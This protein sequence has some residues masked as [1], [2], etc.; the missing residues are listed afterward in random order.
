MKRNIRGFLAIRI[1]ATESEVN[2]IFEV[3]R[4]LYIFSDMHS[5]LC[6]LNMLLA[7]GYYLSVPPFWLSFQRGRINLDQLL[8]MS[9]IYRGVTLYVSLRKIYLIFLALPYTPI[10][11]IL[12]KPSTTPTNGPYPHF[13]V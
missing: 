9:I 10:L 2:G 6:Y 12:V 1:Y 5:S 4:Q 3:Y 7:F 8:C 11:E 13:K